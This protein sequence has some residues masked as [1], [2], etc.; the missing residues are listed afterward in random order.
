MRRGINVRKRKHLL[1]KEI[2]EKSFKLIVLLSIIILV[3]LIIYLFFI[4]NIFIKKNFEKDNIN[5]SILNQNIPFSLNKIILFSSAT[6][7]T[8]NV[9]QSVMNL[10][11]S[12]YC[13][14]GIYLN[15]SDMDNTV[16]QSLFLDNI[17]ISTP[18]TGTPCLYKKVVSDLGKCSYRDNLVIGN[19]YDFNIIS[20][21]SQINYT[22]YELYSDGSTPISVGFF[23]KNIKTDFLAD[24][25]EIVYNGKLLE[26]ALITTSSLNVTVSFKIN[27]ITTNNEHYICNVSFDIPF[28]NED[29]TSIYDSG[30]VTKE[31]LNNEI[32][33][34]IRVK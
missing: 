30:Y 34:F 14:V 21:G 24:I 12:Q 5:F 8:S 18:E 33:K 25:K 6:A 20:S 32:N 28:N 16:I 26:K 13:D 22:N 19:R 10:D 23:N 27:I 1:F 2:N 3:C 29:G 11:I 9:N 7:D 4:N 31:I 15:N 17:I